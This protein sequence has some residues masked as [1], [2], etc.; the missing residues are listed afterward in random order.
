MHDEVDVVHQDP[1]ALTPSLDGVGIHAELALQPQLDL[2]GNRDVLA[3]I[4]SI[5]R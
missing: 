2:V 5:C 4:R 3:F 1:L